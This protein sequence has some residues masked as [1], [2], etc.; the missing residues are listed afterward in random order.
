MKLALEKKERCRTTEEEKEI[1]EESKKLRRRRLA[2]QPWDA[3]R[4]RIMT[5]LRLKERSTK[6]GNLGEEEK[7]MVLQSYKKRE[8]RQSQGAL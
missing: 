6:G 2:P 1:W 3:T 7:H 5:T 4:E 8:L